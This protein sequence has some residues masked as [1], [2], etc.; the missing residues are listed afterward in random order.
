MRR[1][2]PF[3]VGIDY[4]WPSRGC[5][6][7]RPTAIQMNPLGGLLWGLKN[8]QT[9]ELAPDGASSAKTAFPSIT[10]LSPEANLHGRDARATWHG[11]LA[12]VAFIVKS[13]R[14]APRDQDL[15]E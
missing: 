5:R 12:H 3:R 11:H 1:F 6:S 2:N 13:A 7:A 4:C 8:V 14:Y 15:T 10:L 9:P